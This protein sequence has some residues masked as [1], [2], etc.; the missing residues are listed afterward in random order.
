MLTP[1][2]TFILVTALNH[3][4]LC[5]QEPRFIL[6]CRLA[7]YRITLFEWVTRSHGGKPERDTKREV[8][9]E[10]GRALLQ[11]L[12]DRVQAGSCFLP[13][14]PALLRPAGACSRAEDSPALGQNRGAWAKLTLPALG[15][16]KDPVPIFAPFT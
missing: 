16:S 7:S 2:N 11:Q 8:R 6:F 10:P 13:Q 9:L 1:T 14:R 15:S 3:T 4:P 12:L 5:W